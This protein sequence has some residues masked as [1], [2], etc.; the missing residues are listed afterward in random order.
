MGVI[1]AVSGSAVGLGN[2][3]R[4]P[5]QAAANGGGAFMIPYFLA[6]IFL[7]IPLAWVEWT[8]GRYGG[9]HGHG[10]APG[11]FHLISGRKR[12]AKYLGVIA[13][14]GPICIFFYYSYIEGWT[15]A[16]AFFTLFGKYNHITGPEQMGSFLSAFQ[17]VESNS[18]F[19]SIW[20]AYFFFVIVFIV[21]FYFIYK[22]VTK[23]I[24]KL[25]KVALPIMLVIGLILLVRVVTLDAHPDHPEQS[26]LNGLGFMWNPDFEILKDASVWLAAAGQMFF[27]L[28]IGLGA[29]MAYAS[30]LRARDDVALSSLT[31]NSTNEFFE[32][33]L[34]G[35]IVIPATFIFFGAMGTQEV[36]Q[37]GS[38]NLGFVTMP[39]I[40]NQMGGGPIIGFLWFILLFTAGITSSVSLIQP[41]IT[42]LEDELKWNRRQSVIAIAGVGF[43][44]TNFIIFTLARGSMDELDFWAGTLFPVLNAF[45]MIVMFAWVFGLTKGFREL[46]TGAD[47]KVPRFFGFVMKYI[48]PTALF[49]ILIT[50]FIQ[51]GIPVL[52]L[53]N[54]PPENRLTV[55]ATRF[56]IVATGSAIVILL[57][58]ARRRGR[59]IKKEEIR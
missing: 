39:L 9:H 31:A 20:T 35:T 40:F 52:T 43:V 45:I 44:V 1:L 19:G 8:I 27:T 36:A 48:T 14:L 34:A 47:L 57:I 17:G 29:I 54:V 3:L 7:G 11:V 46:D 49:A 12:W 37:G 42:F 23:G 30:Y 16:Y 22:G 56:I 28:S 6:F 18:F 38:F 33:I 2:F 15:L 24:E 25:N 32:V 53:Q 21:N 41:M 55:W 51:Q 13:L 50:W 26:F 5:V 59:F 4:F 10:S 58:I